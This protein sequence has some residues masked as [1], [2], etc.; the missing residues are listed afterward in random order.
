MGTWSGVGSL[1]GG[2]PVEWDGRVYQP[3]SSDRPVCCGSSPAPL[4]AS[5]MSSLSGPVEDEERRGGGLEDLQCV[6]ETVLAK[7][8]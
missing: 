1:A 8:C 3:A 7:Q 6:S 5:Q 4:C 2:P